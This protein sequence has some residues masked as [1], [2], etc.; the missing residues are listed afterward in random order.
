MPNEKKIE[1]EL[2]DIGIL[3]KGIHALV[4]IILGFLMLFI[5]QNFIIQIILKITDGELSEDPKNF[6][7][8]YLIYSSQNFSLSSKHFIVFYLLSHGIIKGIL[9][10]NL[11]KKRLWA[12]PASMVTFAVFMIYQVIRYTYTH[13]IWLIIFTIFDVFVIW[14]IWR[15]YL[16]IKNNFGL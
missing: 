10:F 6:I 14:L 2:F 12:Y 16:R 11:F 3:L 7:S 5:S 13:S 8:N 9:V 1:H 4:E 15:E